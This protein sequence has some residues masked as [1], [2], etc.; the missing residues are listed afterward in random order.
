M[1]QPEAIPEHR[2][3]AGVRAPLPL[4]PAEAERKLTARQREILDQLESLNLRAGFGD[5]TMA[6]L[7]KCVNC[8]LRTLYGLAPRKDELVLMIVD[9]RLHRIGRA[10]MAAIAP[11]MNPIEALRAYLHAA[12]TALGPATVSLARELTAVAGAG[13]LINEHGN[14]VIAITQKLL[15]RALEQGLIQPVDTSALALVLGGLGGYFSR[16]QIIPLI[17]ATPKQ[18]ADSITE[19]ILRGLEHE[20]GRSAI[21]NDPLAAP[22]EP[23]AT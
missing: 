17:A 10:A 5:L 2:K 16:P 14:Y 23:V 19:I 15:D 6:Q 3:F 21:Q 1:T 18:A 7:A 12:T 4:L 9:R 20:K 11:E 8:S 22:T 13:R